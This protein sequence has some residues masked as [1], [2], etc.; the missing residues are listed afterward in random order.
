L[1][2]ASLA[3]HAAGAD[4]AVLGLARGGVPVAR[5]VADATG[6]T[7]GVL[8]A[9]RIG[10]PGMEE[11]ALGAIAEGSRRFVASAV[12]RYIGVPESLGATLAARERERL[13]RQASLYRASLAF[14]DLEGRTVILVDDGIAT[15]ATLRAAVRSVRSVRPKRVVAA[16]PVASRWG[17]DEVRADVDELVVLITPPGLELVE[18]AYDDY[19][20][21]TDDDVLALLRGPAR[22]V[23]MTVHDIR[24]RLGRALAGSAPDVRDQERAIVIPVADGA[25][26]GDLGVPPAAS[27]PGGPQG[28]ANARG[29]VVLAAAG[30]SGRNDYRDR[31]LA[32][33]LRMAGY[34]TLRLDLLTSADQHRGDGSSLGV[35]PAADVDRL[36]AR[37][38]D[39]CAWAIGANIPGARRTVLIGSGLVGAVVLVAAAER[40][41]SIWSVIARGARVH[42][43]S[44][45]LTRVRLAVLLVVGGADR[46]TASANAEARRK[47]PT[48]ARLVTVPH[49]GRGFDEPGTLGALAEHVVSWLERLET[50][51]SGAGTFERRYLR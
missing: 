34:A 33:R 49:A 36:A 35:A 38:A 8:T 10:V 25:V 19:R 4:V 46:E 43:A 28:A 45:A 17:A 13:E 5:E 44:H 9:R 40:P 29:L 21:L 1:L 7:F 3:H 27:T 30:G 22:R 50:R 16:A 31:Y 39:A 51:A 20:A 12:S 48:G 37:V 24:E 26:A 6:A 18:R 11:V 47:L 32:G 41:G 42:L 15:G 2:A 14:P 23:S